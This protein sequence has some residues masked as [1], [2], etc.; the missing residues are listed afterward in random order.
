[1]IVLFDKSFSKSIDKI[2]EEKVKE[3]ILK[4]IISVEKADSI[5]QILVG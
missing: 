3:R 1:M 5:D 2:R 4:I